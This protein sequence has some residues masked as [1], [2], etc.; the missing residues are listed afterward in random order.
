MKRVLDSQDESARRRRLR[1][2]DCQGHKLA[3]CRALV[4]A[5]KLL[6]ARQWSRTSNSRRN[7]NGRQCRPCRAAVIALHA[8]AAFRHP[9]TAIVRRLVC[10][11]QARFS[12]RSQGSHQY[13]GHRR[14]LEDALQH[15]LSLQQCPIP[16][17]IHI[18]RYPNRI[19]STATHA[20]FLSWRLQTKS[21]QAKTDSPS[22]KYQQIKNL[23]SW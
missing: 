9:R 17:V 4:R 5:D 14:A 1:R 18:T 20:P 22:R 12:R 6:R 19:G 23:K 8:R 10:R 3:Q 2:D 13:D 16:A 21:G 15:A 11:L 7:H